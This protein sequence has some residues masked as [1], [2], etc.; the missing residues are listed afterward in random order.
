M[1]TAVIQN[2]G[3]T[4]PEDQPTL[5]YIHTGYVAAMLLNAKTTD[6]VVG[7]CGTGQGFLN[8]VLQFPNVCCG[9]VVDPLDA[10]LF[11]QVNVGNCVA[12]PLNKGYGWAG[13]I[14]LR[15][16]FENLFG[17]Q[18]GQGYP[19]DRAERQATGRKALKTLSVLTHRSMPEILYDTDPELLHTIAAQQTFTKTLEQANSP[20][21]DELL[22]ILRTV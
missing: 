21:A 12:L 16:V 1:P 8:C 15:Q 13:E 22:A 4:C 2:V 19:P 10:W 5:S 7:G 3:M 11:S 20:L 9:L 6:F 18:H 14:G 17:D